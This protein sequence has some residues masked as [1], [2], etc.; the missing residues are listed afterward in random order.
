MDPD[1]DHLF[2]LLLERR[3]RQQRKRKRSCW[4]RPILLRRDQ[5]GEYHTL[6]QEMRAAD[7][8]AHLRY[9]RMSVGDF[10]EL[11]A[12]I[13]DQIRKQHTAMRESISP[14]ERL[15]V[16]LRF[17]SAGG[18]MKTVAESY[19][20]GYATV[21]K[22]IAEVCAALWSELGPK[23]MAFPTTAEWHQR[24]EEFRDVWHFPNCCGAVDGKHV[25][26]QK[27]GNSGSINWCY[28]GF[29]SI[30]LMAVVDAQYRFSYVTVGSNGQESDGGVWGASDLGIMLEEQLHGGPAVLPA[31]EPL[32]GTDTPMPHVLVG[33][34]AFPLRPYMMRPFPCTSLTNERRIANYRMC[35]A[36]LTSENAFGILAQRWRIYR[37]FIACSPVMTRKL[38]LA[39]CVLH[40]YLRQ[41]DMER[42][43]A[44]PGSYS[45][46]GN[47]ERGEVAGLADI[48][49]PGPAR[50]HTREAVR[51]RDSFVTFFNGVGSVWWQQSRVNR[52]ANC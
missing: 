40:N 12:I 34:E 36:R 1:R 22:I 31:P 20:I 29:C 18:S 33:D 8:S 47:E 45:F 50:N 4:V 44:Q 21:P 16:T 13:Q 9:F 38:V 11:L 2:R 37:G 24:A 5:V 41:K 10:D 3:M 52:A 26:I 30:V 14:G 39:T 7:P 28:K 15:A 23:V 49:N 25:M 35:R 17:L 51:V 19:R 48:C 27:P 46:L 43:P 6:V 42:Q 32:P